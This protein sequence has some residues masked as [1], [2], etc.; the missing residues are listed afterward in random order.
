ME[1][2]SLGSPAADILAYAKSVGLFG[3]VSLE[4]ALI[5]PSDSY[6]E[7]YYGKKVTPHEILVERSVANPQADALKAALAKK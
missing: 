4:G 2:S 5:K 6:N 3:G 7:S 1:A